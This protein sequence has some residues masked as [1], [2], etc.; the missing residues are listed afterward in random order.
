MLGS[1]GRWGNVGRVTTGNGQRSVHTGGGL[2][3]WVPFLL[4]GVIWGASFLFI[5]E[6]LE[7]FDPMGVTFLRV[8]FGFVTLAV[9]PAARRPVRRADHGR[10]AV[11]GVIWMAFPLSMFP[12][13][14]QHVSSAL[15]GMLNGA[16]PIFVTIVAMA[17]ARRAPSRGIVVGLAVGVLGAVLI[18]LPGLG[19]GSSSLGA[20]G[21]ILVAL[22]SYGFALN[23]ASGL[24]QRNG[25]LPVIW[26]ALGVAVVLTAPFG[27]P[28]VL[29]GRPHPVPMLS[30]VCLGC[31]GTGAAYV[32]LTNN[33]GRGGAAR[34]SASTFLIPVVSLVLGVALRG[35]DVAVLSI[36]GCAVCLFGAYLVGRAREHA[37]IV[38]PQG[39]PA[40]AVDGA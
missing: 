29:D 20:I 39:S 33:A 3:G 28:A 25:G 18:A 27:I 10:I 23:L 21:M 34:A 1:G 9:F 30:L 31:L 14:E 7:S 26:R 13:A 8:L 38:A 36:A 22:V 2:V 32:I 5:A 4:P 6:G 24:Q 11:L 17:I 40:I 37:A 16:T 12:F 35:D 19:E 15:T